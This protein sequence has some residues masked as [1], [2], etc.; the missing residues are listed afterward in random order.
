MTLEQTAS[1][2][3]SPLLLLLHFTH[4]IQGKIFHAEHKCH[5]FFQVAAMTTMQ[6]QQQQA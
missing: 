6:Q 3:L 1:D 2:C 5:T 4:F